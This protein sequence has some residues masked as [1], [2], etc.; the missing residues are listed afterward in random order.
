[1]A[2]K[3]YPGGFR[4]T[5][6]MAAARRGSHGS[7]TLTHWN[8]VPGKKKCT[9]GHTAGISWKNGSSGRGRKS[10]TSTLTKYGA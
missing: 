1:M 8:S 10:A 4:L 7:S 9:A 2:K 6:K 5:K 3:Y